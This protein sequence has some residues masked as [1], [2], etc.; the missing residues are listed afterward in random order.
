M[1]SPYCCFC[2]RSSRPIGREAVQR[3]PVR[4]PCQVR[5]VPVPSSSEAQQLFS[6]RPGNISTTFLV[7]SLTL[8]FI[9]F[10][11]WNCETVPSRDSTV[12]YSIIQCFI[13]VAFFS[14]ASWIRRCNVI[15]T[16]YFFFQTFLS[17]ISVWF[18]YF[19]SVVSMGYL[20]A[21]PE[22]I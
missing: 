16:F 6:N 13:F 18:E 1:R 21:I 9:T 22:L 19:R 8:K 17:S 4:G 14:V 7:K 10:Q 5:S 11:I 12:V 15:Y 2:E 20:W 3:Q